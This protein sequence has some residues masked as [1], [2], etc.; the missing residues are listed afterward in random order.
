[1]SR[2]MLFLANDEHEY[3][4]GLDYIRNDPDRHPLTLEGVELIQSH[5]FSGYKGVYTK[6]SETAKEW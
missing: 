1:M 2:R 3:G 5:N 4:D 6:T